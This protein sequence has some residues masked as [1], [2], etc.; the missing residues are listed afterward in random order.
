MRGIAVI[1]FFLITDVALAQKYDYH[2]VL[3]DFESG[4][5]DVVFTDTSADTL[6]TERNANMEISSTTVSDSAGHLLFYTNG[7]TV[8]NSAGGIMYN[9]DSINYG[10][11]WNSEGGGEYDWVADII[12][13]P[14]DS[15]NLW[16]LFHYFVTYNTNVYPFL[17]PWRIEQTQIDMNGDSG[18][19]AVVFKNKKIIQDTIAGY[20]T[21]CR[22]ANGRDWW[23]LE[24][25]TNS[26]CLHTLLVQPDTVMNFGLQCIGNNYVVADAGQA[27]FSPDGTKFVWIGGPG[28]VNLFDFD[29]CNGVLSNPKHFYVADSIAQYGAA[30][31]PDSRF[32][33]VAQTLYIFQ[34]DTWADSVEASVDTV[35]MVTPPPD[36]GF[37][38]TYFCMQLA[39][40]GKIY[41][42]AT[43]GIKYLHVINNPN[44]KGDSCGMVNYGFPT[45]YYDQTSL[46]NYPNYRLGPLVGS[47]C[48][49]I[50]A[51]CNSTATNLTA[52]VCKGQTYTIG[53][54]AYTQTGLYSD[55]LRNVSGCDSIV[56]LQLTVDTITAQLNKLPP[57]TLI[58]AGN[59]TITW[60][61]CATNELIEGAV[62]DT[63]IPKASGSYAAI[64]TSANCSDTSE[65]TTAVVNGIETINNNN[66]RIFPNPTGRTSNIV[67][68]QSAPH[69]VMLYDV[70]GALLSTFRY[71]GLSEQLDLSGLSNGV[72]FIVIS[73]DKWTIQRKVIKIQ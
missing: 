54:F 60:I 24:G 69:S 71:E 30:F 41:I 37:L 5:F 16:N 61:D 2:W 53:N 11:E 21:A 25:V 23:I 70:N 27:V 59:G 29:R 28:G 15:P 26:N 14:T 73:S 49:T 13:L 4:N 1:C 72:Y 3:G 22:H 68:G 46:P 64:I 19:G 44:A 57:D 47:G 48:D 33:Y 67:L 42:D 20:M 12:A 52:S 35:G 36:S 7:A 9:G 58:V 34:F 51:L 38:G 8:F 63:F 62:S 18:L 50:P 43:N 55:T 40:N 45:P 10:F 56:S 31:S 32:L 65:C 17:Y 39:P 66:V 6:G